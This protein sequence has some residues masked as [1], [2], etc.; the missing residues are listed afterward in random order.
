MGRAAGLEI[1][2]VED[3]SGRGFRYWWVNQGRTY[4]QQRAAGILW[5]PKVGRHGRSFPHWDAMCDVRPGDVIVHY[6]SGAVRAVST[7]VTAAIDARRP[8]DLPED[9]WDREGRMV[10]AIYRDAVAPIRL[11]DIPADLISS[12]PSDGP[13]DRDGRVKQGYLYPLS[14]KLGQRLV[15]EFNSPVSGLTAALVPAEA[16]TGAADLLRRLVGV[17]IRT[18][19]GRINRIL[20]IQGPNVLVATDSSPKGEPVPISW[21]DKALQQLIHHGSVEIHPDTVGHHSSFIGAVLLTLPGATASGNPPVITFR[22]LAMPAQLVVTGEN[23]TFEGDLTRRYEGVQ[24]GEQAQLRRVL[25]G[26]ATEAQCALCGDIYPVRF[27][28]AAHIKKRAVCTDDERR[29]LQH[30][31]MPACLFGCDALFEAGYIS[32]DDTGHIIVSDAPAGTRL[33][34]RLAQLS[35]RRVTAYTDASAG[36]FAWHRT[37][38]YRQSSES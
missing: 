4:Q 24:R 19:T 6:A 8:V 27:L 17:P 1:A 30:I 31:A 2:V 18:V 26:S 11:A 15:E 28:W 23:L 7:A 10:R 25:F 35:G 3:L 12:E 33:A 32:V 22:Q 37:N 16:T 29:D 21:V 14:D 36:Y 5:A 20:G 9:L 13:F 38:I 34:E